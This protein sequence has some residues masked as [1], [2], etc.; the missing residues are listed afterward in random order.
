MQQQASRQLIV[1]RQDYEEGNGTD[2]GKD[3]RQQLLQ[4]GACLGRAA[5][6][7]RPQNR[8]AQVPGHVEVDP[9]HQ[10]DVLQPKRQR[11]HTYIATG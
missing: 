7:V 6:I 5:N 8:R 11:Q 3:G 2:V 9:E 4:D 1:L 10:M